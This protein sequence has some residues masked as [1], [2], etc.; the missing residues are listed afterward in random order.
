MSEIAL[1]SVLVIDDEDSI[2]QSFKN[3]LEDY[4][5]DVTIA[6]NGK[7]GIEKFDDKKPDL[8]L[9]DLRMPEL[10]GLG[11][12]KYISEKSNNILRA[13]ICIQFNMVDLLYCQ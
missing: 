3:F 5:F 10:D 8:V 7:V 12:L 1:K 4:E 2:R 13:I 6:E 11:V 9:V